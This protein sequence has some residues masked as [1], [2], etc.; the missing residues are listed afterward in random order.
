MP[1]GAGGGITD[2]LWGTAPLR[3]SELC[4]VYSIAP[5]PTWGT[6]MD[7]SLL[8]RYKLKGLQLATDFRFCPSPHQA[9]R[10]PQPFLFQS[11]TTIR[12]ITVIWASSRDPAGTQEAVIV[13][14]LP[15]RQM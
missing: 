11:I 6:S 15:G 3:Q 4:A 10:G 2:R 7:H 1:G 8:L 14:P 13:R 9:G 12:V 5:A